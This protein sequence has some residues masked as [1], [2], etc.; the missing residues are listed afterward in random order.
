MLKPVLVIAV[1]ALMGNT[2]AFGEPCMTGYDATVLPPS[3]ASTPRVSEDQKAVMDS[4][5]EAFEQ[6]FR[7]LQNQLLSKKG[8]LAQLW[9]EANPD[10][11]R[12]V[13]KQLEIRE[14][15]SRIE[16]LST[17]YRLKCR[18]ILSPEQRRQLTTFSDQPGGARGAR[19]RV[20]HG[21]GWGQYP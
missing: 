3:V 20:N 11:A 8:E 4:L 19:V 10:E 17:Q 18:R 16:E 7:P 15:Q 5:Y 2:L 12:I 6:E 9:K 13:A 21:N 1:L 14:I